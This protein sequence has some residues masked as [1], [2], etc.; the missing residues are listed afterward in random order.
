MKMMQAKQDTNQ[1][2]EV[3]E[4]LSVATP[5]EVRSIRAQLGLTQVEL[6]RDMGV[7]EYSVWRW[8]NGKRPITQA[9]TKLLR[10]IADEFPGRPRGK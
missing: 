3:F 8:E 4:A 9:H 10:R 6:A 7:T 1:E 2:Y 5:D